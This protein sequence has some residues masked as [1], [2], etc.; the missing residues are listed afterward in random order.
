MEG[1]VITRDAVV[2]NAK[3]ME[4][5]INRVG[6]RVSVDVLHLHLTALYDYMEIP[7]QSN[8]VGLRKHLGCHLLAVFIAVFTPI[9]RRLLAKEPYNMQ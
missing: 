1:N 4:L 2:N 7:I 8:L 9:R 6:S 5:A 3:V